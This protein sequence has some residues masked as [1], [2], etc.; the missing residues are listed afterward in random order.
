MTAELEKK[1]T[2]LESLKTEHAELDNK[3]SAVYTAVKDLKESKPT[4]EAEMKAKLAAV[5]VAAFTAAGVALPT[6]AEAYP[7]CSIPFFCAGFPNVVSGF[8][9]AYGYPGRYRHHRPRRVIGSFADS[10]TVV[11]HPFRG[12]SNQYRCW[13]NGKPSGG[14]GTGTGWCHR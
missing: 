6:T 3:L 13:K 1:D 10:V 5:I 14:P 2:T 12:V 4:E 7:G 8:G 11:E 9:S